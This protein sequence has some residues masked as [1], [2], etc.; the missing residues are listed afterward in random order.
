[1]LTKHL[2]TDA[3]T[4]WASTARRSER[5]GRVYQDLLTDFD[6]RG[7][8]DEEPQ[9]A[10]ESLPSPERFLGMSSAVDI[11]TGSRAVQIEMLKESRDSQN[12]SR[13]EKAWL[14]QLNA[15]KAERAPT[16]SE[17]VDSPSPVCS[18]ARNIHQDACVLDTASMRHVH[19]Y[20]SV[21][22]F[23]TGQGAN[24]VTVKEVLFLKKLVCTYVKFE[25]R[26]GL[27]MHKMKINL[28]TNTRWRSILKRGKPQC[29]WN[30]PSLLH[31]S[32]QRIGNFSMTITMQ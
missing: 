7:P 28:E 16:A 15:T 23:C 11:V 21:A 9:V 2:R 1:M 8:P 6:T 22:F 18:V 5:A 17:D 32:S 19:E 12:K 26:Q 25:E 29:V 27:Y 31:R 14:A 10:F 3:L 4:M 13:A 24:C 30:T 20:L